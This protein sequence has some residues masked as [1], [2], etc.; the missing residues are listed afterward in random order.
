L[1]YADLDQIALL[2][3]ENFCS[4]RLFN[5]KSHCE[6]PDEPYGVLAQVATGHYQ[7]GGQPYQV[8]ARGAVTHNGPFSGP[9][10]INKGRGYLKDT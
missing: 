8:L 1:T 7:W 3:V 9:K 6:V 2:L 5:R 4:G 10:S